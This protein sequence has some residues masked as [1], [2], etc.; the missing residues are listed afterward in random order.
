LVGCASCFVRRRRPHSFDH[1]L[2]SIET[3]NATGQI[4]SS[5]LY[6][7]N[8]DGSRAGVTDNAGR[9]ALYAYDPLGRLVKETILDPAASPD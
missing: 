8:P 7:L 1:R 3:D 5:S 2:T 4:V 9:T 6:A